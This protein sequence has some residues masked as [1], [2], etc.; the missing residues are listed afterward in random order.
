MSNVSL[1]HAKRLAIPGLFGPWDSKTHVKRRV[2]A[3]KVMEE[4]AGSP[5]IHSPEYADQQF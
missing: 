2:F 5:V 1:L 3:L 4:R